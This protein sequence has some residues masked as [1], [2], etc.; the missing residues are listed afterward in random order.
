MKALWNKIKWLLYHKK[1]EA[2]TKYC[3]KCG[4]TRLGE[5]ATLNLK[6]CQQCLPN[7]WFAWK[8]DKGQKPRL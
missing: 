5:M 8:L 1:W 3:P 7:T 6:V 4:N 2:S